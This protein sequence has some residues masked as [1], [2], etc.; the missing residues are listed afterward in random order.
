[1]AAGRLML[2]QS[3]GLIDLLTLRG[4]I[5]GR[6]ADYERADALA[7]RLVCDAPAMAGVLA[8][9]R[10]RATLHRFAEALADLD[11]AEQRGADQHTLDAER[12]AIFQALGRYDEALALR[13]DAAERRPN[14]ATL[15]ALAGLQAECGR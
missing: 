11:S 15:G 13:W 9:A 2:P 10:A 1:M 3:A 5:L 7:E 12:A 14:F 4:H 6:I 8:R